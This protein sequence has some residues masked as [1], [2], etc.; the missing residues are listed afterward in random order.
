M[1]AIVQAKHLYERGYAFIPLIKNTKKNLDKD[2]YERI[3]TIDEVNEDNN[4]GINLE[5]SNIVDV[6]LDDDWAIKFGTAW[7]P[8]DTM[9]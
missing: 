9:R 2:I 6:D 8:D 5:K 3:Y 4:L 7:L 1:S